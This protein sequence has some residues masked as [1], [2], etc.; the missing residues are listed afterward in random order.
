MRIVAV[1]ALYSSC[2]SLCGYPNAAFNT[3][4]RYFWWITIMHT[5]FAHSISNSTID[6]IESL[7]SL[8]FV[9][10]AY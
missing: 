1:A 9:T 7:S 2:R 8:L 4:G 5:P 10:N 6:H 3:L